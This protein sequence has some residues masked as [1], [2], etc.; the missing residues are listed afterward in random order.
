MGEGISTPK[1]TRAKDKANLQS[2]SKQTSGKEICRYEA[3]ATGTPIELGE[4]FGCS[5]L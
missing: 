3:A 1:K 2:H 5:R 4:T